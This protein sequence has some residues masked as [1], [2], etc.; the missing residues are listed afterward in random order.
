MGGQ[1]LMY[2]GI[3]A[4]LAARYTAIGVPAAEA[5]LLLGLFSAAQLVSALALPVLAHRLRPLPALLAPSVSTRTGTLTALAGVPAAPPAPR[6][7]LLWLG[8]GG[9]VSLPAPPRAR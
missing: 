4:W 5:G 1:S 2:Y 3:L 8:A 9:E 7:R 6:T